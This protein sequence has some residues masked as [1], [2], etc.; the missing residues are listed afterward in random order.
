MTERTL[1]PGTTSVK[2]ASLEFTDNLRAALRDD[3]VTQEWII[4][5]VRA[6]V[7]HDKGVRAEIMAMAKDMIGVERMLEKGDGRPEQMALPYSP[8]L[9]MNQWAETFNLG[10]GK[11]WDAAREAIGQMPCEAIEEDHRTQEAVR[12]IVQEETGRM[13]A[14][15]RGRMMTQHIDWLEKAVHDLLCRV[16]ALEKGGGASEEWIREIVK[17]QTGRM[18]AAERGRTI[19]HSIDWMEKE[20]KR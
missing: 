20:G 7:D 17:E 18:I 11:G 16:T 2:P 4:D 13:I 8:P 15:E 14:V 10:F 9:D 1:K 3:E 12:K 5:L 19:A 6:A